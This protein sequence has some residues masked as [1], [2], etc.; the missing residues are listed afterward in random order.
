MPLRRV[1]E[2]VHMYMFK[3]SKL[4][5]RV[6]VWVNILYCIYEITFGALSALTNLNSCFN[7]T[8]SYNSVTCYKHKV[9]T[10]LKVFS[11]LYFSTLQVSA[12]VT[13]KNFIFYT[14]YQRRVCILSSIFAKKM[15]GGGGK[16]KLQPIMKQV[17]SSES[18]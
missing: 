4:Q 13:E 8:F 15:G 18:G 9:N 2:I 5:A 10:K 7:G 12:I 16:L 6:I 17:F 1:A 14:L 11:K 3:I